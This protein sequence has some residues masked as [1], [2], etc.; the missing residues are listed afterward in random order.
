MNWKDIPSLAALRAFEALARHG[1]LSGAARE[2]NVTHAAVSQHL[3]QLESALDE[4][5]A[6]REGQG[7]ALT[8]AGRDL[9]L[10]LG[11]GFARIAE[12]V[13]QL[14][15]RRAQRLVVVALTPSFAESWLMPRIGG[16]WSAHPEVEIRLAPSIA[17]AICGATAST[18]PSGSATATGRA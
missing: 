1:S 18:S 12:G 2:L 3:R 8:D 4:P 16:F 7:M 11:E 13:A 5:L 9:A 10:A 17:L 6:R 14:R 15:D